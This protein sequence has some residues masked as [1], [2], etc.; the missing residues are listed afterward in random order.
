MH[1]INNH[2]AT[3]QNPRPVYLRQMRQERR[4]KLPRTIIRRKHGHLSIIVS[5]VTPNIGS[6]VSIRRRRVVICPKDVS[7]ASGGIAEALSTHGWQSCRRGTRGAFPLSLPLLPSLLWLWY[8]PEQQSTWND[9]GQRTHMTD[10]LSHS[11]DPREHRHD[12]RS[13]AHRP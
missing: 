1:D 9:E 10:Q 4:R 11:R 3:I 13:K 8:L 7:H 5:V 6:V 12:T 2:T